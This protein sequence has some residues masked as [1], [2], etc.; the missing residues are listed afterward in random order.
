MIEIAILMKSDESRSQV[1]V[2]L[3][4]DLEAKLLR[5]I[6]VTGDTKSSVVKKYLKMG[7]DWEEAALKSYPLKKVKKK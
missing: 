5:I 3:P 4:E 2:R 6:A 7:L 1:N